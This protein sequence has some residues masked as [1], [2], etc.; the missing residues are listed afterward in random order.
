MKLNSEAELTAQFNTDSVSLIFC[1]PEAKPLLTRDVKWIS[2]PNPTYYSIME[3]VPDFDKVG[4]GLDAWL[5][6]EL[7]GD[8]K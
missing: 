3:N 2:M 8:I 6:K 5:N 1:A 4:A 7:K